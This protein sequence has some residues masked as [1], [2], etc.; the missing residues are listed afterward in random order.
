[1]AR[2]EIDYQ[3]LNNELETILESLQRP[4]V[5]VD[6]AIKLYEQGLILIKQLEDRVKNAENRLITLKAEYVTVD[7]QS[8]QGG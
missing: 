5:Q 7:E 8:K 2:K 6:E 4:D 3:I 1:M